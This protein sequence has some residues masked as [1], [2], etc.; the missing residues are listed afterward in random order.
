MTQPGASNDRPQSYEELL[1]RLE[2]AEE[3]IR[4]IR[5]GEIDALVIRPVQHEQIFTLGGDDNSYR[6][7]LETMGHG[8]A[9][10]GAHGEILYANS[11]LTALIGKPLSQLQGLPFADAVR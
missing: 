8:A 7:F 10:L 3:T 9:A 1:W 2:E 4:A 6:A 11:I 5:Q